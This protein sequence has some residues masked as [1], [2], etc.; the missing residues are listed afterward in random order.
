MGHI[1]LNVLCI[2]ICAQWDKIHWNKQKDIPEGSVMIGW[3]AAM[4]SL[5]FIPHNNHR[6]TDKES[7]LT[8][9]ATHGSKQHYTFISL[10]ITYVKVA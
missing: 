6:G 4:L 8:T 10:K 3:L 9:D 5:I 1:V 2:R 7:Q